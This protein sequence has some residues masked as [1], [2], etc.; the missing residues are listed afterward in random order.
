M[1]FN[2]YCVIYNYLYFNVYYIC[3]YGFIEI[4]YKNLDIIVN[5]KILIL[6]FY[7]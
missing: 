4:Y 5:V 3:L 6:K 2:F 1:L 7:K